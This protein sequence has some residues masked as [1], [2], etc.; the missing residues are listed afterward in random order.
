MEVQLPNRVN[1]YNAASPNS[2]MF[3]LWLIKTL[4]AILFYDDTIWYQ[5]HRIS[6]AKSQ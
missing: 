3:R 6:A 1:F 5:S 2:I 4:L